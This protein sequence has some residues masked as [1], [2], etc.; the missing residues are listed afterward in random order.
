M[1]S[2]S[3][4][5][6]IAVSIL[7]IFSL[8]SVAFAEIKE[9]EIGIDGLSCPFCVFGLKEQMK[10]IEAIDKLNI[11]LKNSL[12]SITLKESSLLNIKDFKNAV[13]KAGFSIREIKILADGEIVTY[14]DFLALKIKETNQL[15]TLSNTKELKIGT[16]VSIKGNVHEHIEGQGADSHSMAGKV[17]Q[18]NW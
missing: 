15:F 13:K 7:F 9:V 17:H 5:V 1:K 14:D 12:A 4:V 8:F 11:N 3:K 2:E 10:K 18:K 6:T 16:K